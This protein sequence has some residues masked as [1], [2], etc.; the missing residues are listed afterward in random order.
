M[1]RGV[2]RGLRDLLDWFDVADHCIGLEVNGVKESS[3]VSKKRLKFSAADDFS[4]SFS[5][6]KSG[7]NKS[8]K[9]INR[10]KQNVLFNKRILVNK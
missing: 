8:V 7:I 3:R 6:R 9:K 10:Y 1:R 2:R 5:R 4:Y